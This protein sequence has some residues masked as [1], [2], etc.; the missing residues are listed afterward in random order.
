VALFRDA[1]DDLPEEAETP[2][3]GD[4]VLMVTAPE[5][6]EEFGRLFHD[7]I[8]HAAVPSKGRASPS[9][10]A[11]P[12]ASPVTTCKAGRGAALRGRPD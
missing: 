7:E 5:E 3:P 9:R 4:H 10:A 6:I 8:A 11:I 2:K 12:R 1:A